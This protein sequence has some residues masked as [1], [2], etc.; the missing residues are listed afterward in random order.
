MV[1]NGIQ[2]VS[3]WWP[4]SSNNILCVCDLGQGRKLKLAYLKEFMAHVSE[5]VIQVG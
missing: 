5:E 2:R 1:V 3:G 4:S